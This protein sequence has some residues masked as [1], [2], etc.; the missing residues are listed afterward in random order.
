LKFV[1]DFLVDAPHIHWY[2]ARS[3]R[4]H[5]KIEAD[6]Q[7]NLPKTIEL[8]R[9]GDWHTP[10]HGDFEI[11]PSDIAQFVENANAGVGLVEGDKTIPINYGHASYDKA[12]GW[13][14]GLYASDDG[15]ALLTDPEWTPQAAQGLA[16][17][18]WKYISPEF[19]PRSWPWEDPEEE[20]HFVN[21]V[22]TGAA[23]T[24]IPL[25]KK[26]KPV[27]ASRVVKA[28]DDPKNNNE[29]GDMDLATLRAKKLEDLKED[30]KAFLAEHKAELTDDERKAFEL[31]EAETAE[32]KEARE[33]A[34]KDAADKEAADKAAAEEAERVEAARKGNVSI[35]ASKLAKLEAD[36]KRGVEAAQKLLTNEMTT[37]VEASI[38]QGS[39]KSDQ[40][41]EAVKMLVEASDAD[42]AKLTKFIEAL[43][44]NQ[45]IAAGE[46]GNGGATGTGDAAAELHEKVVEKIKASAEAGKDLAYTEAQK[47]VLKTDSALAGR[48]KQETKDQE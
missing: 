25:F 38:K 2:M 19:N 41:D 22:L 34:E 9:V 27:M 13:M 37:V 10:W 24:N 20:F 44:A 45:L 5:I 33:Q 32:A 3:F 40:K 6:A 4:R 28:S 23:L 48:V 18:E 36:A 21:N 8:L 39:V 46:I 26:L 29:G 30:E 31:E 14:P 35:S 17:K 43:P 47:Q 1:V 16:E 42:R 12:S 15:Q 11:T 7:G